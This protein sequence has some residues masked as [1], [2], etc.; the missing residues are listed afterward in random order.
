MTLRRMA[1]DPFPSC[2][3]RGAHSSLVAHIMPGEGQKQAVTETE[4]AGFSCF[5]RIYFWLKNEAI[6]DEMRS[7]A[8]PI[9]VR[10]VNACHRGCTKRGRR[11]AGR[12]R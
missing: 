2:R 11:A 3:T 10:V 4:N 12:P 6:S 5:G 9:A 7:L 1:C 8:A